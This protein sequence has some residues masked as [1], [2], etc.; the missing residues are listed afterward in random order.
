MGQSQ[1][2]P[3][4]F[5]SEGSAR[6]RFLENPTRVE[7]Y[8]APLLDNNSCPIIDQPIT[9]LETICS[10]LTLQEL[11]LVAMTCSMFNDMVGEFL[12]H[13][14][15]SSKLST[16][17]GRFLTSN[18]GLLTLFEQQLAGRLQEQLEEERDISRQ[19][20]IKLMVNIV[21]YKKEVNRV[22]VVQDRVGFPHRDNPTYVVV[23][24]NDLLGREVVRV[25]EVC[26]LQVNNTWEGVRPGVFKVS[27]L[28]KIGDNFRWPHTDQQMTHWTVRW[29]AE[30]VAGEKV[31]TV[32]KEWWTMISKKQ[33]PGR[34]VA[35]GHVAGQIAG[36]VAGSVAGRMVGGI[37]GQVVGGLAGQRAGG[38]VGQSAGRVAGQVA[39]HVKQK[40]VND[41]EDGLRV[42]WE[43]V[44]G[45]LT[46]WVRVEMPEMV[47]EKE[48]DISFELKD[49]ECPW[50]KA[51]LLFDFIELRRLK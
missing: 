39:R 5:E 16:S 27:I 9:V 24:M 3:C 43:E 7:H 4:S 50:W 30:G 37:T 46:G 18:A 49:V 20:M 23:E 34:E 51:D 35:V 19:D 28:I 40:M 44:Q 48:G 17:L 41:V 11:S 22:S 32:S 10:F 21:H 38:A 47:V 26:W 42:E 29:P 8:V 31:V 1:S 25:R 12:R 33:T 45:E 13:E 2:A 14:C 36:R 15:C 6:E